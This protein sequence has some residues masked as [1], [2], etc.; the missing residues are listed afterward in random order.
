LA[1]DEEKVQ[2]CAAQTFKIHSII[3]RI[4]SDLNETEDEVE[5]VDDVTL[6]QLGDVFHP[7]PHVENEGDQQVQQQDL[8]AL[9]QL[10]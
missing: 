9:L 8:T 5:G 3:L 6:S 10:S 4:V 1:V 7:A 2:T